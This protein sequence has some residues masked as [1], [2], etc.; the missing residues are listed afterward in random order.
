L[1]LRW[2][3]KSLRTD[4]LLRDYPQKYSPNQPRDEWGQWT[5]GANSVGDA[6]AAGAQDESGSEGS[7]SDATPDPLRPGAQY[8]EATS[9]RYSVNLDEEE[10]PEASG[11]PCGSMSASLMRS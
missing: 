2:L 11:T 8:A 10:A 1:E 7:L 6:A 5:S 9:K 4:L 3:V